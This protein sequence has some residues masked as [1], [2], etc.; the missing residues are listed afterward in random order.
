MLASTSMRAAVLSPASDMQ[1]RTQAVRRKHGRRNATPKCIASKK[2]SSCVRLA[3]CWISYSAWSSSRHHQ[4]AHSD[5]T[6]G[7]QVSSN[8]AVCVPRSASV[9]V[10]STEFPITPDMVKISKQQKKV[11][12]RWACCFVTYVLGNAAILRLS[13]ELACPC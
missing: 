8:S 11:T 9:S 3:S 10:G 1:P 4:S 2:G 13:I 5:I 12:G 6:P 7:K